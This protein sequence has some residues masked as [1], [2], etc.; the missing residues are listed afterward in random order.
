MSE[1]DN[2]ITELLYLQQNPANAV[3]LRRSRK[4]LEKG[5][6]SRWKLINSISK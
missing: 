3:H 2:A 1:E 5:S 6:L 4:Q